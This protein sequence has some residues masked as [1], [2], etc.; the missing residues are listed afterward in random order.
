VDW[1]AAAV[2][3]VAAYLF[4][5]TKLHPMLILAG[6]AAVGAIGLVG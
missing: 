5:F 3:A 2:V 1:P 4:M 6:S